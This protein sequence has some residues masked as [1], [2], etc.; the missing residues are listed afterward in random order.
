MR[1]GKAGSA[2]ARAPAKHRGSATDRSHPS[3]HVEQD[4]GD[5]DAKRRHRVVDHERP[6]KRTVPVLDP[7][8]AIW[9]GLVHLEIPA[10]LEKRALP[11][12]G[13]S[14]SEGI[15]DCLDPGDL[16]GGCARGLGQYLGVFLELATIP[17]HRTELG[18]RFV[19]NVGNHPGQP[20]SVPSR[21]ATPASLA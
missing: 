8:P 21:H 15:C 13:A 20:L 1:S 6:Q 17:K 19:A 3:R 7:Q 11:A 4:N 12:V 16:H 14:A 10:R 2:Q 5:D 18:G 9:A